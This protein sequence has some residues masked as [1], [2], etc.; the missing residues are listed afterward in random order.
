[1]KYV[2]VWIWQDPLLSPKARPPLQKSPTAPMQNPARVGL[3]PT[4]SLPPPQG[5]PAVSCSLIFMQSG[6]LGLAR[7]LFCSRAAIKRTRRQKC[8]GTWHRKQ[9]LATPISCINC[10]AFKPAKLSCG[11]EKRIWQLQ[12]EMA[13]SWQLPLHSYRTKLALWTNGTEFWPSQP[14]CIKSCW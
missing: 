10:L 4:Q 6:V 7:M 2:M 5:G 11:T 9:D 14:N 3:T 12:S 1:M 8:Q 13:N